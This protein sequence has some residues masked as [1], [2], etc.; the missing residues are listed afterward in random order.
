MAWLAHVERFG[1]IVEAM[2]REKAL[3]LWKREWKSR[4]IEKG[5]PDWRDLWFDINK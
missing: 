1:T 2:A 5:N 4:L 3:K